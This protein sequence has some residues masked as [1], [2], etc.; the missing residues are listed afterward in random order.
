MTKNDFVKQAEKTAIAQVYMT[1]EQKKQLEAL[2][3]E[4]KRLEK[5]AKYD[6]SYRPLE[7]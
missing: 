5:T 1:A 4:M 6:F 2:F 7:G 3:L